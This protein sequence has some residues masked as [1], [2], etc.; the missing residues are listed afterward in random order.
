MNCLYAINLY[1]LLFISNC[2][3]WLKNK[4]PFQVQSHLEFLFQKH[5]K[6]IFATILCP[7][8]E[9]W[10]HSRWENIVHIDNLTSYSCF[11]SKNTRE[12]EILRFHPKHSSRNWFFTLFTPIMP[13]YGDMTSQQVAKYWQYWKSDYIFGFP[14][15][16]Y[17]G[18]QIFMFL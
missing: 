2:S 4:W 17:P 18:V 5:Q 14:V 8:M 9:I 7:N 3:K 10:R 11:P 1:D 12:Y 6:L 15:P 13:K 16:K